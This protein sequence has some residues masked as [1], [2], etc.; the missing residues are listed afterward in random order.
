MAIKVFIKRHIKKDQVEKAV[1]MLGE[2][3]NMAQKEPGYISGETLTNHFDS[4]G[5]CQDSCRIF[6]C[7]H[8]GL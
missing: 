7:G 3:R 5:T 1:A 2:F 6:L 8:S 4:R